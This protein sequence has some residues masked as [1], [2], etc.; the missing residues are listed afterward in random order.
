MSSLA[1]RRAH[2][3]LGAACGGGHPPA[4]PV[5]LRAV[6]V[7]RRA[8]VPTAPWANPAHRCAAVPHQAVNRARAAGFPSR[9]F[10][11]TEAAVP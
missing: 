6:F 1:R 7:N 9:L 4:S 10:R 5:R 2:E 8:A 11:L 3:V